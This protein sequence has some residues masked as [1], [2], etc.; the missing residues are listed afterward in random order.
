MSSQAD[1]S[2][3]VLAFFVGLPNFNEAPW[4]RATAIIEDI[5]GY[6]DALGARRI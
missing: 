1:A 2:T 4:R 5:A 6:G 3:I